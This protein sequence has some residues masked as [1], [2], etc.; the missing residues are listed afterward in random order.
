MEFKKLADEFLQVKKNL[1]KESTYNY[2]IQII[3]NDLLPAIGHRDIADIRP[4]E[5]VLLLKLIESEGKTHKARR[6]RARIDQIYRYAIACDYCENNPAVSVI[7]ALSPHKTK[8]MPYVPVKEFPIFIQRFR[9]NCRLSETHYD[10]WLLILYTAKRRSEAAFAKW[11][12]FDI[13]NQLWK[14]PAERTKT[15]KKHVTPI[16]NQ[17]VEILQRR[18]KERRNQFVFPHNKRDDRAMNRWMIWQGIRRSGYIGKM[19]IHGVRKV[20]STH[21]HESGLWTIDSIELQLSHDIPGVRG[22]YNKALKINERR[23]LL[24]WWADQID[25][26]FLTEDDSEL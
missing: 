24:Q 18:F 6:T 1:W 20:F 16:P 19:S 15:G 8:G 14:I 9:D 12:E 23:K 26:W 22:I 4:R 17:V 2:I 7:D 10:A 3:N 25:N 21:A 5:I 11:D 13:E